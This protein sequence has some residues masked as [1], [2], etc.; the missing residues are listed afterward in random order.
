MATT[1]HARPIAARPRRAA[2]L[3]TVAELAAVLK[4]GTAP[5]AETVRAAYR[6]RQLWARGE[7]SCAWCEQPIRAIDDAEELGLALVHHS[8]ATEFAEWA[9]ETE[10][11]RLEREHGER[12]RQA[13]ADTLAGVPMPDTGEGW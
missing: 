6:A 12:A 4:H 13:L 2:L 1:L 10:E 3:P 9:N 5:D 7:R 8:C 11:A